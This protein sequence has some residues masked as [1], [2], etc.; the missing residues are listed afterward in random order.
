MDGRG[1]FKAAEFSERIAEN[2]ARDYGPYLTIPKGVSAFATFQWSLCQVSSRAIAAS[3]KHG[4]LRMVPIIDMINHDVTAGKFVE[5]TGK[6]SMEQGD[7]MDAVEFED[8]GMFVVRSIRH[9]RRKPLKKGQELL[10]NYNVD[11]YSPLDWF[12]GLGFVPP[13][14]SGKWNMIEAGLPKIRSHHRNTVISTAAAGIDV[15]MDRD[16]DVDIDLD[17][18]LDLNHVHTQHHHHSGSQPKQQQSWE[19]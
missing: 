14:R 6:E 8:S 3:D 11:N 19:L 9:G 5:L 15:D 2:L 10:V 16:R 13:E 18:D 7:F 12:L 4:A 17:L 1:R